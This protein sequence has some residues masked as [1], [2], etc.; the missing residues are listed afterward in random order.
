MNVLLEADRRRPAATTALPFIRRV[1][2]AA[3]SAR[4]E[5]GE[6]AVFKSDHRQSH[7]FE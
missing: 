6:P 5:Q 7:C 4:Q 1:V 2:T 3:Q